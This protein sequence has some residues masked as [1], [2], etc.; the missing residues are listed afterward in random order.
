MIGIEY[1][2]IYEQ[3]LTIA[4]CELAFT[5]HRTLRIENNDLVGPFVPAG[6]RL[7]LFSMRIP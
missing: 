3:D 1:T 5:P 7:I 4:T 6:T 2:P